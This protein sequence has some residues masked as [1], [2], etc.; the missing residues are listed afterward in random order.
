MNGAGQGGSLTG[1]PSRHRHDFFADRRPAPGRMV[2]D[3]P[4]E[5]NANSSVLQSLCCFGPMRSC[6]SRRRSEKVQQ[7]GV[8][9]R[10]RTIQMRENPKAVSIYLRRRKRPLQAARL[11]KSSRWPETKAPPRGRGGGWRFVPPRCSI[12]RVLCPVP[13]GC[14]FRLR[15]RL[16]PAVDQKSGVMLPR[17]SVLIRGTPCAFL[18]FC[19]L[20][21]SQ[22]F[23]AHG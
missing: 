2:M 8:P 18:I 21:G 12:T 13:G 22:M 3:K 14:S 11:P 23:H 6:P 17:L 7:T 16:P 4:F 20:V 10:R 15:L 19:G 5:R 1:P 9:Q